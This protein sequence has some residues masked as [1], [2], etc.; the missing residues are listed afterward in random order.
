VLPG[1]GPPAPA[2]PAAENDMNVQT[3]LKQQQ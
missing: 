1:A 2:A 3:L